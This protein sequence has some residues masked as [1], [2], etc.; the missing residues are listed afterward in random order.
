MP[1]TDTQNP[2]PTDPASTPAT[3][4]P[5]AAATQ[6]GDELTRLKK[7]LEEMTAVAKR[8]MADL[9]NFK[10]RAGEEAAELQIFAN[11]NL[12]S[13]IFPAL[14]NFTRAFA[15]IPEDLQ[16]NDWVNGISAIEAT[17]IKAL[18]DTGL[19]MID[20]VGIPV[21]PQ[22]HEVLMEVDAPAAAAAPEDSAGK[23]VQILEKGYSFRGR[24]LRPAK[25]SVGKALRR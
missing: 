20:E 12:L 17:L 5:A 18:K 23:V 2:P 11:M 22:K 4:D 14:D 15:A 21:D 16:G 8:A 1:D 7:E 13:A 25:V 19:E 9:Q 6:D 3:Q 10:R 24:T